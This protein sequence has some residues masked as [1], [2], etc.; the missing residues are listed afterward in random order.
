MNAQTFTWAKCITDS[1]AEVVGTGISVDI[2]GNSYV[3]GYFLGTAVFDTIHL[4]GFGSYDVFIAKYDLYGNCL[5][6]KHAGG[7][8][9][10]IST[11]I[12]IDAEG[13]SY[14]TGKFTADA[15]FDSVQI[16]S[17]DQNNG[18]IFIAKY[19]PNGNCL[20]A[21]K[22]GGAGNEI[23]NSI[24][25]NKN[26]ESYVTGYFRG[27]ALFDSIQLNSYG[28]LDIFIA[29]YDRLGNCLWANHSGGTDQD[30]GNGICLDS[31]GNC[32]VTGVFYGTALFD[33]IQLNSYGGYGYDIFIAKYNSNGKILWA[34]HAGGNS[35]DEG[36]SIALD[37]FGHCYITG[38]F[39]VNATFGTIQLTGSG[40]YDIFISKYDSI[41]NCLWVRDVGS[42]GDDVSGSIAVDGFG[43][44][45]ITGKFYGTVSFGTI[46]LV[47]YGFSD[48]FIAKYNPDGNCLWAKNAGGIEYDDGMGISAD[49]NGNCYTT[50]T[51]QQSG[52][53]GTIQLSG[54][55]FSSGGTYITKI[56]PIPS[57]VELTAF[58]VNS[59][60]GTVNLN[61][62]TAT[63]KNNR[64]FEIQRKTIEHDFTTISFVK[65]NGTST[66]TNH[67]SWSE[68][69]QSGKYSYK[70]KQVD[71]DGKFEFSSQ[72][73]VVVTPKE[74]SLEQNYPN[75]F[76]P[77]TTIAYSIPTSGNVKLTIF[78]V[79]G[80]KVATLVNEYKPAGNY[81]IQFNGT[82]LASGIYLYRLES[83]AYTST[84]KLILLK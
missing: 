26:E 57:P 10:D 5:W 17:A 45:Y 21:K 70:L 41:G 28:D 40:G 64:G 84:K 78:N 76:N 25:V 42:T 33:S 1:I 58:N 60:N 77:T 19:D 53:F 63:E 79:I 2:N 6:A 59:K 83:G 27:T 29:K 44:S 8:S 3:T 18:D 39:E 65:G 81:S 37:S 75:P 54:S 73:D 74:F 72:V 36:L 13:N 31:N 4:N 30:G 7:P 24:A 14:I 80:S 71:Y 46:K 22:A 35:T 56:S 9:Y 38:F 15:T 55:Y 23:G 32:Y 66:I 61:W 34:K 43:N 67:Y 62:S 52:T 82:N 50:G 69:L 48:I 12:S 20:W 68:K 11:S 51:F 49:A 16:I 47:S